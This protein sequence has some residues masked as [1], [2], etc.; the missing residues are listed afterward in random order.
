MSNAFNLTPEMVEKLRDPVF[1]TETLGVVKGYDF[2]FEGR[3][4]LHD[5]Y[6]DEH[7]RTIILASR[8]VEKSETVARK[9]I[10]NA[11]TQHNTTSL[12]VSPRHDQTIRFSNDRFYQSLKTSKGNG[13][14]AQSLVKQTASHYNFANNHTIYF[15]SAWNDGDSLR[16]VTADNICFDEF[17][18]I[19][20]GAYMTLSET[21]SHSDKVTEVKINGK[22]NKLRGNIFITGTPKQTGSVYEKFWNLSDMREWNPKKKIWVPQQDPEKALFRGY[23]IVQ[24]KMPWITKEELEYKKKTYDEM[25]YINEVKGEFYSGLA[26]PLTQDMIDGVL[27]PNFQM[28]HKGRTDRPS[29]MGI[30]WGGGNS[31]FTVVKIVAHNPITDQLDLI[32][33]HRFQE[34][35]IPTL[36]EKINNMITNFN[37]Q[38]VVADSGFGAMQI[39]TLQDTYGNLIQGCFYVVGT[40]EPEEIKENDDSTLLTV[41]RSYQLFE[42]IDMIKEKRI[43]MPYAHPED[44]DWTFP[45]YT[46]IESEPVQPTS[47]RSGYIRIIHPSGTNDDGLHA[48]N[49]ARIA[50]EMGSR[51][52]EAELGEERTFAALESMG[53][54]L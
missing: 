39:Q 12:Y 32:F 7:P 6:R 50:Y 46:C 20:E 31:A 22:I 16:G 48:L 9:L 52:V 41:D 26:K 29:Y 42:T 5:I 51:S 43:R 2:S 33:A 40:R 28:W 4:H 23:H 49:Y 11:F 35:H 15:G 8:Q 54:L 3:E 38:G 17:Q 10:H 44:I 19:E 53:F 18:D 34:R 25:K 13:I 47:G 27:D 45:H 14:L 30:D 37:V 1:F 24:E 21:L 36:V